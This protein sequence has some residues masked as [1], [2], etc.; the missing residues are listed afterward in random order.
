MIHTDG[1][2]DFYLTRFVLKKLTIICAQHEILGS[3]EAHGD[4]LYTM[5]F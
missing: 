4:N 3:N 5:I 2:E 1:L